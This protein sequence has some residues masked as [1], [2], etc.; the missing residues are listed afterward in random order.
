MISVTSGYMKTRERL[1]KIIVDRGIVK[2][3]ERAKALIMAGQILVD[4]QKVTKAG[5]LVLV[6]A[7]IALRGKDI[8]FVSRGGVKLAAAL[9]TFS[10][11]PAGMT[12]MDV[13]CST[14]GFTDCLLAQGAAKVYAI[15]VGYGQLDWSLRNDPRIIL[16]EKTNIRYLE[17]ERIPEMLDLIVI[18][19]SFIS[20]TKVLPRMH[21]FLRI[22]GDIIAL[23][24]PQ[25]ELSKGMIEKGGIVRDETKR[26]SALKKICEF[27]E[28]AR[29]SV[30]GISDSPVTGQKGNREYFI[31]LRRQGDG[32]F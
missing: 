15:D 25:F 31:H 7:A 3:R 4:D 23:V 18:D 30:L 20:L 32:K 19:V 27:S 16:L 2:S 17:K 10:V 5:T 24:K 28:E 13:G 26:L 29:L 14:G 1:D 6:D 21:D 22:S 12:V 8:P 11:D 9:A